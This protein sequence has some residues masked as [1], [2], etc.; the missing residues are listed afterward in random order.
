MR[1][2][3]TEYDISIAHQGSRDEKFKILI[4]LKFSDVHYHEHDFD[5]A[6]L[7]LA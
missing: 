6:Q 5:P 7:S 1:K 2:P 4:A 3:S